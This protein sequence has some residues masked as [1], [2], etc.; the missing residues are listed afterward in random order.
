MLDRQRFYLRQ[1]RPLCNYRL[2]RVFAQCCYLER[3]SGFDGHSV[4]LALPDIF[5]YL[6]KLNDLAGKKMSS[7]LECGQGSI[8]QYRKI[9][10]LPFFSFFC[11]PRQSCQFYIFSRKYCA[12]LTNPSL[13]NPVARERDQGEAKQILIESILNVNFYDGEKENLLYRKF[14][15]AV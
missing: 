11:V 4:V 8:L 5:N 13:N 6:P 14:F 12:K 9:S 10:S 15:F 1:F 2:A 7:V 3:Y